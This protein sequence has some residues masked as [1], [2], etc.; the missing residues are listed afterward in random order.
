MTELPRRHLL[1]MTAGAALGTALIHPATADASAQAAPTEAGADTDTE[2]ERRGDGWGTVPAAVPVPLER[3]FDNDGIDVEDARGGDFDGSGYTF[4]GEELPSG[5][6]EFGGIGYLFPN[7]TA[8][9]KNNIVAL[10]Q[11]IELPQGRYL[12]GHFLVAC[13]YGAVS[14]ALTVHYADGSTSTAVLGG[15]DWY[16]GGGPG[17]PVPLRS[18]RIQ[19]PAPGRHRRV[20]DR[21]RAGQGGGGTHP[22]GHPSGRTQRFLAPHL[23]AFPPTGRRGAGV[24]GTGRALDVLV[25]RP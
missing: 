23:R 17:R 5:G 12:S 18:H 13:S 9:A 6:V 20:R 19:G 11:R 21:R 7:A 8:G 1:G 25:A 16:V 4:P 10:G 14:G 2:A 24:G 15:P 3:W 22:A